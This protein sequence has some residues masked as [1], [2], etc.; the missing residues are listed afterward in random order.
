[1]DGIIID[2]I[3]SDLDNPAALL[4]AAVGKP[5]VSGYIDLLQKAGVDPDI[6]DVRPVPVVSSLLDQE[7]SP[8]NG[9]Y[10]DLEPEHPSLVIFK[11]KRIVL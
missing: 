8:L 6:I 2:Y 5:A 1:V 7:K 9:I 11:G 3:H 10:L 4:T